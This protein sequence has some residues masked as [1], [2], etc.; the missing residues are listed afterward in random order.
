MVHG[1]TQELDQERR[2]DATKR[3]SYD[4]Y[5]DVLLVDPLKLV[6]LQSSLQAKVA[7]CISRETGVDVA[8]M[9]H[10]LA[11]HR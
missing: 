10:K 1:L 8:A 9:H 2:H 3:G 4:H 11:T 7:Q 5:P 6:S